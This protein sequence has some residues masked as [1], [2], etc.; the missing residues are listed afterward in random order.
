MQCYFPEKLVLSGN[1][2]EKWRAFKQGLEI[3]LL[4]ADLEKIP[5][6]RKVAILLNLVGE[7]G[8]KIYN[9]F[10]LKNEEKTYVRILQEF[11]AYCEPKKNKLYC[12]FLFYQRCQSEGEPF[13]N[14]LTDI[15]KLVKDCGFQSEQEAI[16][17]RLVL[18]TSD[19]KCQ[20]KLLVEGDMELEEV[21]KRLRISEMDK[22]QV[23]EIQKKDNHVDQVLQKHHSERTINCKWCG[24]IHVAKMEKCPARGKECSRC[25]KLNHFG[26]VCRTRL[27]QNV[28]AVEKQEPQG[29]EGEYYCGVREIS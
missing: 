13:D 12:R 3:Y 5:D 21:I 9:N 17:D 22:R 18:G 28:K 4:A 29:S 11:E 7:E 16:R 8:I 2:A 26:S 23:E 25:K 27:K 15:N 20:R 14:F 6:A 10:N 1:L 24:Q 19:L